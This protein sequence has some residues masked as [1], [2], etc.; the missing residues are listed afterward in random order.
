[1]R[2]REEGIVREKGQILK[3]KGRIEGCR[4]YLFRSSLGL[5]SR[6]VTSIIIIISTATTAATTTTTTMTAASRARGTVS[7]AT[8]LV[9]AGII[10]IIIAEF[11]ID[12]LE[13]V[14]GSGSTGEEVLVELL[15]DGGI[16]VAHG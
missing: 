4:L 16:G 13:D 8:S 10:I 1:M 6:A 14:D 7:A 3:K 2:E 5:V 12:T 11:G 15:A 9:V